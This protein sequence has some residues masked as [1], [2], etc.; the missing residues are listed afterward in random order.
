MV[1]YLGNRLKRTCY[2]LWQSYYV[3]CQSVR[4]QDMRP[5]ATFVG[6]CREPT[7]AKAMHAVASKEQG[8][9]LDAC[10]EFLD[11]DMPCGQELHL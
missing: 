11:W 4:R 9:I 10:K 7:A 5:P 3:A 8:L 6:S 2:R 1:A